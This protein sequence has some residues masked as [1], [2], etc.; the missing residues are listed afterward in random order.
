MQEERAAECE[1]ALEGRGGYAMVGEVE[2]AD[3]LANCV[4]R[5]ERGGGG[6][7]ESA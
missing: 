6:A 1:E 2:E 4:E 7:G 3:V 5:G